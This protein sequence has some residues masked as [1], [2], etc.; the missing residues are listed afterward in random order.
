MAKSEEKYNEALG[1]YRKLAKEN[2]DSYLPYVAGTLNNLA[3]LHNKK[4]ELA[5]SEENYNEA[6]GIY[7]KLAEENPAVYEIDVARML[8]MGDYL[9]KKEGDYLSEAMEI[10]QRYAYL[11]EA[12][13]LMEFAKSL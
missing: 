7:R 11:P 10:L 8:L 6:L 1:I 13:E 12:R 4:N 9:F 5:K 3:V 2:P